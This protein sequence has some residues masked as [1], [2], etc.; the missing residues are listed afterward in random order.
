MGQVAVFVKG[1]GLLQ[2]YFSQLISIIVSIVYVGRFVSLVTF[3]L[4][5]V[6]RGIVGVLRDAVRLGFLD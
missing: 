2:V 1:V 3:L 5:P 6:S 4:Q